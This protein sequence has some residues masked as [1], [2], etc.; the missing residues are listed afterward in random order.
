MT[1]ATNTTHSTLCQYSGGPNACRCE[2]PTRCKHDRAKGLCSECY[3][4]ID[5]SKIDQFLGV[6][7]PG[8]LERLSTSLGVSVEVLRKRRRKLKLPPISK[9]GAPEVYT[10]TA[11]EK[12]VQSGVAQGKTVRQMANELGKAPQNIREAVLSLNEK[13][14]RQCTTCK[15]DGVVTCGHDG[16]P[17]CQI[18]DHAHICDKCG[19][20]GYV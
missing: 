16:R 19:G 8:A 14:A 7:E 12:T 15:G 1:K 2:I 3:P 17:A 9:G 5:W 4:R 11:R 10:L 20:K 18:A 13:I 6:T